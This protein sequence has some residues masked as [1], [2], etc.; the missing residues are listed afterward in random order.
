MNGKLTKASDSV[1]CK[2]HKVMFK[3]IAFAAMEGSMTRNK[4]R[5]HPLPAIA[6]VYLALIGGMLLLSGS[7]VLAL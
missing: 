1:Q 6:F 4:K 2:L 5:G 7:R 3:F